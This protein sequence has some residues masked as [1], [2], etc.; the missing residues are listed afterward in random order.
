MA[1]V[2]VQLNGANMPH[3]SLPDGYSE[4]RSHQEVFRE[5]ADGSVAIQLLR[6]AVNS[7][8]IIFE[9]AWK[10]LTLSELTTVLNAYNAMAGITVLLKTPIGESYLVRHNPQSSGLALRYYKLGG[11]EAVDVRLSLQTTD[12]VQVV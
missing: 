3:L 6:Q 10:G 11:A 12:P 7:N 8:Q 5:M 2:T 9:L 1:Y 4:T